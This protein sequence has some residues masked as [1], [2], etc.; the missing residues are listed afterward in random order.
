[1]SDL[2]DELLSKP[3]SIQGKIQR[4]LLKKLRA[5]TS[6]TNGRFLYYECVQEGV[7][8]KHGANGQRTDQIVSV[9]LMHLR[10]VGLVPWSQITDGTR[11]V[12]DW[13][14][15][16]TVADFVEESVDR[17]RIDPWD[18]DPPVIIT[19]SRALG[20]VLDDLAYEYLAPL[21]PTNGQVGGFLYTDVAPRLLPGSR[22]LYLG[23]FDY[24]GGQI[25]ENTRRVLERLVGWELDWRRI[26]ITG[27]QI[28]KHDLPIISKPDKRFKPV[29]FH[30]VETEALGKDVIIELVRTALDD[31]LPEPL[32]NIQV[33]EQQEREAVRHALAQARRS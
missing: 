4:V 28:E 31:L 23:D 26:A 5:D 8:P 6:K 16:P 2:D 7:V 1:M 17:A 15:A 21:A 18:G 33:R 9:A 29:Q 3:N 10:R 27:E 13:H 12:S 20:G 24:Q 19:E 32:V 22:V 30:A 11:H 25:E 14:S